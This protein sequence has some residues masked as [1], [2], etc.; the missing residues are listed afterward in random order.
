MSNKAVVLRACGAA[1]IVASLA[2]CNIAFDF[3]E[4]RNQFDA[5]VPAPDVDVGALN[6][7]RLDPSQ[8]D[9]GA[10]CIPDATDVQTCTDDSRG[11]PV[12]ILG[13]NIAPGAVVTV[14]GV[15]VQAE[16]AGDGS[17]AAFT[18]VVPVDTTLDEADGTLDMQVTVSQ[19]DGIEKT[20]PLTVRK[21]DQLIDPTVKV[22]APEAYKT[23]SVISLTG[24]DTVT[25][26]LTGAQNEP[27]RLVATAEIEIDAVLD[28]SGV[29][30]AGGG[31]GG[32]GSCSG[33]TAASP[34]TCDG[35][36]KA[37]VMG[38]GGGGAGHSVA[39][40][41]GT[42]GEGVAAEPG[43]PVGNATIAPFTGA[44][45]D[46]SRGNGGGGGATNT[47]AVGGGGGG[48]IELTSRGVLRIRAAAR[49][50]AKGGDG[51]ARRQD[52]LGDTKCSGL[53]G[54]R[55]GAGGGGSGGAVIL[56]AA[57]SVEAGGIVDVGNGAGG[58]GEDGCRGGGAGA[59]GRLRVDVPADTTDPSLGAT[60]GYRGAVPA[61]E[62]ET[63]VTSPSLPLTVFGGESVSSYQVEVDGSATRQSASTDSSRRAIISVE[64]SPGRN[65]ICTVVD[66]DISLSVSEAVNCIFVAYIEP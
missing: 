45:L 29:D 16:I 36:G 6:L 13:S 41:A 14:D 3:D 65:R 52:G 23:Y 32:P 63:V 56:R 21:L 55:P 61:Y 48:V 22:I 2:G 34:G 46:V 54:S 25:Y 4:F 38:G 5:D 43:V 10:G 42:A 20:L 47:G 58:P 24:G 17:M 7:E 57:Q 27:A 1:A 53:L 39:G 9:E 8:V 11:I 49:V 18:I 15:E 59:D 64:L 44:G 31:A 66:P 30:G 12:V 62:T 19:G 37:G 26:T 40:S 35:G 60:I 28:A 51:E 50:D 33:G